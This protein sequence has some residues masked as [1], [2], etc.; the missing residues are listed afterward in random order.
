MRREVEAFRQVLHHG[1]DPAPP[2]AFSEDEVTQQEA[3]RIADVQANGRDPGPIS[4][5]GRA[6]KSPRAEAGHETTQARHQPGNAAASPEILG[7]P[8]VEP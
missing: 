2:P 8:P 1:G 3:Q 6:G 7:G 4:N 5:S